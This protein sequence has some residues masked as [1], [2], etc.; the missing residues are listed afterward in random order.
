MRCRV[1]HDMFSN[2]S[3]VHGLIPVSAHRSRWNKD[4]WGAFLGAFPA[5]T[6]RVSGPLAL[7]L[8]FQSVPEPIPPRSLPTCS[9]L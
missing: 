9:S 3:R 8:P 1:S 4:G 7:L 6:A 2:T 5:G